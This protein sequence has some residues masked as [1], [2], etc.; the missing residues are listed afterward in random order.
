MIGYTYNLPTLS[1]R[2]F[3]A[4]QGEI[5]AY[6]ESPLCGQ[7][8]QIAC[9]STNP[10]GT[11]WRFFHTQNTATNN[12]FA[13]QFD[14]STVSQDGRYVLFASDWGCTLGALGAQT[15]S[16]TGSGIPVQDGSSE[17][18]HLPVTSIRHRCKA[19]VAPLGWPQAR[20][21]LA[22]SSTR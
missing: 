16:L 14:I 5:T 1:P 12:I 2:P 8:G 13:I 4:R 11:I 9:G 10:I 3:T 19:F 15:G 17:L 7:S 6:S 20:I 18:G 21:K 22:I